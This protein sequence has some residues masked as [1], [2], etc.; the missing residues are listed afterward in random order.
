LT[1]S[2][3]LYNSDSKLAFRWTDSYRVKLPL[4]TPRWNTRV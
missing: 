2:S 3:Q 1:T 4:S